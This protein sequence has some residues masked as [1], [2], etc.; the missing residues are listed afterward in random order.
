MR[1][2]DFSIFTK[3]FFKNHFNFLKTNQYSETPE[4]SWNIDPN[5]IFSIFRCFFE[6]SIF[7]KKFGFC[8]PMFNSVEI[9]SV[10]FD[11]VSEKSSRFSLYYFSKEKRKLLV[12]TQIVYNL[13]FLALKRQQ[14]KDFG[15]Y[16]FFLG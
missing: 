3:L 16:F 4:L 10:R 2:L 1:V 7:F 12:F 11:S 5:R 14:Q 15:G 6:Y 13:I 9:K 8:E